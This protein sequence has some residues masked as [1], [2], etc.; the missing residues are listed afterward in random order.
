MEPV[1]TTPDYTQLI[2]TIIQ[3]Q[4]DNYDIQQEILELLTTQTAYINLVMALVFFMS[5]IS[6]YRFLKNK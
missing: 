5:C 1:I 3:Y 4:L 2:E 6:F